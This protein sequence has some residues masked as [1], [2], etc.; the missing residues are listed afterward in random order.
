MSEL[1]YAMSCNEGHIGFVMEEVEEVMAYVNDEDWEGEH[2]WLVRLKDQ[3]YFF[4]SGSHDYT[5]WD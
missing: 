3:R 2:F 1:A 5:G 4:I